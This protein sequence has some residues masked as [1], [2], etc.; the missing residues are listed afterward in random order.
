MPT[1]DCR[2]ANAAELRLD[3]HLFPVCLR[4]LVSKVAVEA[5]GVKNLFEA[6]VT[7]DKNAILDI[8]SAYYLLYVYCYYLIYYTYNIY[9]FFPWVLDPQGLKTKVKNKTGMANYSSAT[10]KDVNKEEA[11]NEPPKA[12]ALKRWTVIIYNAHSV[13]HSEQET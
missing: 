3:Q 10:S 8:S 4:Q 1:T 11:G 5:H 13:I 2:S 12:A 9:I 6:D 7:L